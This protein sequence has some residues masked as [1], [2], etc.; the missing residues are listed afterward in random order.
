MT[1]Q[2]QPNLTSVDWSKLPAPQDD[3]A[4]DH[5]QGTQLPPISLQNTMGGFIDLSKL[6]GL[7][8]LFAYPMTARPDQ[9][10][11]DNWDQIPGA[12]GCTPQTCSFRD[13]LEQLKAAGVDQVFGIS[14]QSTDYQLEAVKRLHLPYGL[15]SDSEGIAR[16]AL[17]LPYMNVEGVA[18]LSR[19]TMAIV[20]NRIEKVWYPVFPPDQNSTEILNWINSK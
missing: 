19:L 13:D 5:L 6:S 2:N 3:G 12:R 1:G 8:I 14:A 17:K 7:T 18:L 11:P 16:S 10:L 15:L 9:E 20:D 4:A